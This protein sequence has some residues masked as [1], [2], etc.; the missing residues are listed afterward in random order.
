VKHY[1]FEETDLAQD[2]QYKATL[3]IV[4]QRLQQLQSSI[5]LPDRGTADPRACE[6]VKTNGGYYGPWL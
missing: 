4:S 3:A 5:S 6:Q 2:Q 1:Q